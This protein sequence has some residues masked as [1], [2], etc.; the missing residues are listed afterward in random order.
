VGSEEQRAVNEED[1]KDVVR[2]ECGDVKSCDCASAGK[3]G[4]DWPKI[5]AAT[6]S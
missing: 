4:R 5:G 1:T 2:K 3:R 6:K